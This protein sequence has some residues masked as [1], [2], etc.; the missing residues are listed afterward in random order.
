MAAGMRST[1]I[2]ND[3]SIVLSLATKLRDWRVSE[4]GLINIIFSIKKNKN[5]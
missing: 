4:D 5:N 3:Y 1:L 2:N